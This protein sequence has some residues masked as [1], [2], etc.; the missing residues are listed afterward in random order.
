MLL[1]VQHEEAA[2]GGDKVPKELTEMHRDKS[3]QEQ[4]D[5]RAGAERQP[6]D[7]QPKPGF[8]MGLGP[9]QKRS[10]KLANNRS[11]RST[12]TE[13]DEI[14]N[15]AGHAEPRYGQKKSSQEATEQ[16]APSGSEN[17]EY[18]PV[19][20]EVA[21]GSDASLNGARRPRRQA[22][23]LAVQDASAAAGPP[24]RKRRKLAKPMR[25]GQ[26]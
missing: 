9:G 24:P 15:D 14:A 4:S 20:T 10:E 26:Q 7:H 5:Y 23:V 17:A 8:A 2:R 18:P 11:A 1:K 22:A 3:A 16:S 19:A 21:S 25:T 13:R 12:S 6:E